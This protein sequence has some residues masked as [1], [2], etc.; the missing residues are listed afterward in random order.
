MYKYDIFN[1]TEITSDI[2]QY[3]KNNT[4]IAKEQYNLLTESAKVR[5]L[6]KSKLNYYTEKNTIS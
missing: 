2:I 1:I 3:F 6:D 4:D 5:G